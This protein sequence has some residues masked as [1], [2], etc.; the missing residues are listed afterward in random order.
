[1][2]TQEKARELLLQCVELHGAAKTADII[3][4]EYVKW[5]RHLI[6]RLSGR[7]KVSQ[8]LTLEQMNRLAQFMGET[9]I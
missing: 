9:I 3:Q 8:P 4:G 7:A 2:T 5:P 6:S 1:M